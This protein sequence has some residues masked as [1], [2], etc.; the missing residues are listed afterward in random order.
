MSL[1]WLLSAVHLLGLGVGLGA[2]WARALALKGLLD[3]AGLRRVFYADSSWGIAAIM[4][5]VTG[6][7]R[8]VG[9]LEKSTSYYLHNYL[10][11]AKMGLLVLILV[12]E[13]SPMIH[14]I[15][16]RIATARGEALDTRRAH[17]FAAISMVQAVLVVLMVLAATGMARGYG[18]A[19]T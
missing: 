13:I 17:R 16:W 12:L 11:L 15:R 14:L 8:A 10:F 5:I 19:R 3:P 4:W 18:A 2:V 9:G 6:L 1:R 7:W